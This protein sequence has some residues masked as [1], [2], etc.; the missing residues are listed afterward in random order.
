MNVLLTPFAQEKIN[1]HYTNKF[2]S[3][4]GIF[5][6]RRI[7]EVKCG[8]IPKLICKFEPR[9]ETVITDT[10]DLSPEEIKQYVSKYHNNF[11]CISY[12]R[13]LRDENYKIVGKNVFM[14]KANYKDLD[15]LGTKLFSPKKSDIPTPLKDDLVFMFISHKSLNKKRKR[16]ELIEADDWCV[17]SDQFLHFWTALTS[18]WCESFDKLI[19]SRTSIQDREKILR[20]KL[21]SKNILL[22]NSYFK[23]KTTIEKA[24]GIIADEDLLKR[25]WHL[26]TE[27]LSRSFRHM[28]VYGAIICMTRYGEVPSGANV[29]N[30]SVNYKGESYIKRQWYFDDNF[31]SSVFQ[32]AG[33]SQYPVDKL[34]QNFENQE[35]DINTINAIVTYLSTQISEIREPSQPIM[36]KKITVE[37]FPPIE[38]SLQ[39]ESINS[40]DSK[41]SK[42]DIVDQPIVL[43]TSEENI[44]SCASEDGSVDVT[45]KV[46]ESKTENELPQ[47]FTF[48]LQINIPATGNW[49]DVLSHNDD[50]W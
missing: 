28:D 10:K 6:F 39:K 34:L 7:N 32:S 45:I 50:E 43:Q 22:V 17:V 3:P 11:S 25:Y 12:A 18:D 42:S 30:Y 14:R 9:G 38:E 20:K 41:E 13:Q 44:I 5:V 29:P 46:G 31:V 26:R 33:L 47:L 4:D 40:A 16:G 24:G 37:D 19:P 21:F 48:N 35:G 1:K 27:D 15:I 36:E 2:T 49:S 8:I 23:Y